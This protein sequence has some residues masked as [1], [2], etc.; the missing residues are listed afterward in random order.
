MQRNPIR[1]AQLIAPFGVGAML[2]GQGGTGILTAGLDHWYEREDRAG[3]P[4]SDE[5]K[6]EEWRLQRLLNVDHFRLPPDYREM[7]RGS[8]NLPNIGLTV[9]FHRFPQWH[10]CPR[11]HRLKEWPLQHRG[12][13]ECP[14]C[15]FSM[16]QVPFV[17]MCGAGHLQ[18]FPWNEWVHREIKPS[19]RG[20]LRL[21][22]TGSASL[23][24][25][26]VTCD[27]CSASS[28]LSQ[29]TT[30]YPNGST[31][32]SRHLSRTEQEY[33]CQGR[34]PWLGDDTHDKCNQHIRGSL[35]SASNVYFSQVKSAIYLP[36]GSTN[37]PSS[38]VDL[39]SQPPLSTFLE[40][41]LSAVDDFL[42][43][44]PTQHNFIQ[45]LKSKYG[46]VLGEFSDEQ[47]LGATEIKVREKNELDAQSADNAIKVS[48]QE[49]RQEEYRILREP[50]ASEQLSIEKSNMEDYSQ[51]ISLYFSRVMLLRK[52][53]ETRV[54]VGFSRVYPENDQS[55]EQ[56]KAMLRLNPLARED[57]LPAYV[58]FG[59]GI[60]FEFDENL[61]R[62]WEAN[63]HVIRRIE[64]LN[65]YYSGLQQTRRLRYL[66][67][68]PRFVLLHTFSHLVMN[69]LTFECG[70]S[71]ASLRERLY[72][73]V[74]NE[75]PMS[76]VLIYTADGDAEG[77]M[78]G[79]V[80]MGKPGY[81]EPVV[82]QALRGA[83]WCSADP[84]CMEIGG[85]GGQGPDSCNLAA[86]H[87]CS[88]VPETACEHFNR[89]LDRAIVVGDLNS[90]NNMGFFNIR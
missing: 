17:A 13:A 51:E 16:F 20:P 21:I 81:L 4:D 55:I 3:L 72:V 70:Y 67:I 5:F 29:I 66:E 77:T 80:R 39:F 63:P 10:F 12:K 41:Y 35:R 6:I 45:K 1:R 37:I 84:V 50:L 76:G 86:C 60:F 22:S 15:R 90:T 26:K 32:L 49:F 38:L 52:L 33:L 28:Y 69:Q 34:K 75:N 62:Q 54:M 74:D 9:P 89:F 57:W 11:C 7:Q 18:D 65:N 88:L 78:G 61:L 46:R 31:Y 42:E 58:V 40:V 8:S 85:S 30:A 64:F 53:R 24:G 82:L 23:S 48:E 47:I 36:R 56:R 87:N 79:L 44:Q 68:S 59:E 14:E 71:S 73:S 25:Q 2:V 19:C 83:I 27:N 43:D